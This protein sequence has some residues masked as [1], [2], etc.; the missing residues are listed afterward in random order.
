MVEGGRS[1]GFVR[2]NLEVR[3]GGVMVKKGNEWSCESEMALKTTELG[4][5]NRREGV[6][7]IRIVNHQPE[8]L[9]LG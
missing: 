5:A 8:L 4:E 1:E 9:E 6:D 3:D 7:V 2:G